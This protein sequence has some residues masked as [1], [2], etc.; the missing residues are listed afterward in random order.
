MRP[1]RLAMLAAGLLLAAA[2]PVPSEGPSPAEDAAER[3]RGQG[4]SICVA[5][6]RAVPDLG[7]D[8]LEAICGCA[9]DL[10]SR[11]RDAARLPAIERGRV[12]SAMEGPLLTCT[13]RLR[14]D[15]FGEVARLG[16]S[17]PAPVTPPVAPPP[18]AD[19][20]PR[21]GEGAASSE[22]RPGGSGPGFWSWAQGLLPAWLAGASVL[23]WVGIG[24][25]LFGLAVLALR[26]R[27]PRSDLVG[28][29]SHMRCGLPPPPRRPDLPR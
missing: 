17:A 1:L 8:D 22:D 13:S 29:P 10:H 16:T 23:V 12:R 28:P 7:P 2:K 5:E 26:R 27:D 9:F 19:G 18:V 25:F 3:W 21:G 4:I 24:I 6:L 20:K 15:R 11:G 14:P